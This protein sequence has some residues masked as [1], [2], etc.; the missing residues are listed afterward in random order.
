MSDF[1]IIVAMTR[2]QVIGYEN[3]LPWHLPGDLQHFKQLTLGKA[4]L[5]GR[6]TFDS[7]GHPLSGR[8][9]LVLTRQNH[10]QAPGCEVLH[11]LNELDAETG[12]IMVIGGAE[13]YRQCLPHAQVLHITWV[14]GDFRG[15]TCFPEICWNEWHSQGQQGFAADTRHSCAYS[16][17]TFSRHSDQHQV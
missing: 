13:I 8:R 15:D 4:I 6:K 3:Q 14:H 12:E 9:N 16:F 2:A 10:W 1:S 7:I 5:M 17:E 11:D